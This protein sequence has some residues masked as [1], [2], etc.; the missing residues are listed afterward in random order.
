MIGP[1]ST[2]NGPAS[3]PRKRRQVGG[4]GCTR[5]QARVSDFYP[6]LENEEK[7]R[8]FRIRVV[9]RIIFAPCEGEE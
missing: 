4:N 6:V 7:L 1:K 9:Q 8:A 5:Y 2:L 3:V